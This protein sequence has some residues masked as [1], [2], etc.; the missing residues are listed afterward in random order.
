MDEWIQIR[1]EQEYRGAENSR[2]IDG[3]EDWKDED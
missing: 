2:R 1:A 3:I